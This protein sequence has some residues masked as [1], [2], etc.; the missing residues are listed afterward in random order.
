MDLKTY[1]DR[2]G[3]SL[4]EVAARVGLETA[5][6]VW[7]H[8]EGRTMPRPEILQAYARITNGAVTADDFIGA[9]NRWNKLNPKPPKKPRAKRRVA[10]PA[11]A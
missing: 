3:W 2:Q 11:P 9:V 1:R 8:E 7:K 6:A 5:Q 4:A 10:E